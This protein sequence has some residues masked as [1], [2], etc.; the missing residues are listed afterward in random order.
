MAVPPNRGVPP[1]LEVSLQAPDLGPSLAGGVGPEKPQPQVQQ[2]PHQV[3]DAVE[4]QRGVGPEE[5]ALGLRVL[6][7]PLR[8]KVHVNS[9]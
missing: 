2:H 7:G 1:P 8:V 6:A 9:W 5:L 4:E 3:R